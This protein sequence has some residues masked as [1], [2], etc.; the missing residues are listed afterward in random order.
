MCV[1]DVVDDAAIVCIPVIAV[2]V[3]EFWRNEG[4]CV[5]DLYLSAGDP[6]FV[7]GVAPLL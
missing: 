1:V 6:A 7:G 2:V 3:G 4:K 5:G